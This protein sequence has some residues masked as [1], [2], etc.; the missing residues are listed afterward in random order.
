M[1]SWQNKLFKILLRFNRLRVKYDK[2]V[3]V[4]KWRSL[5]EGLA[6]ILP[7]PS[8]MQEEKINLENMKAEWIYSPDYTDGPIILFMHGGGYIMGSILS[9]RAFAARIARASKGKLLIFEYRLAPE[10]PFPA[11]VEDA[12]TA[13]R[14]LLKQK[15]DPGQIVF[16]GDSA[17]GGLALATLI[18][19][20]D[21]KEPL[22][23]AAVC[24][25]PWTDL[26]ITGESVYAKR[27]Q[28]VMFT[29]DLIKKGAQLYYNRIDPK[30]P[31]VSPLYADLQGLPPL[32]V[33]A[34]SAELL[35]SDSTRLAEKAKAAGVEVRLELWEDLFHV[36]QLFAHFIPEGRQAIEKIGEFAQKATKQKHEEVGTLKTSR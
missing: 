4:K 26:A 27:K 32:L 17:G 34:G 33:H 9:Y 8:G 5:M 6:H 14:W 36:F 24:L 29:P 7:F 28:D 30:T 21:D 1:S 35:L 22:P 31:L 25:S 23:A 2:E 12:L 15:I 13:Y 11:A 16:A 20:R 10:N 19:L 3:N 18:A